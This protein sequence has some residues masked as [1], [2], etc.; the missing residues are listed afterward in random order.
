MASDLETGNNAEAYKE[1]HVWLNVS[2]IVRADH[3]NE[4]KLIAQEWLRGVVSAAARA[5]RASAPVGGAPVSFAMVSVPSDEPQR[6]GTE[7][8]ENEQDR[9]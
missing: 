9:L 6:R 8:Q 5:S 4:A 3:P 1:Y 7:A 2:M